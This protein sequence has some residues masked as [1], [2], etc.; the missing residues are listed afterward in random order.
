MAELF[1]WDKTIHP[2]MLRR[3]RVREN[4]TR[5]EVADQV[6]KTYQA[7]LN[8]EE[9]KHAPQQK[10]L[11]AIIDLFGEASFD[12]QADA[13]LPGDANA[14]GLWL[15]KRREEVPLT[16]HQFAETSGI[17]YQTIYN[18]ETGRTANPQQSTIARI[19][20][21]LGVP[22]PSDVGEDVREAA[23][24]G[25]EGIGGLTDFDPHDE[26]ELPRVPGIY[27]LYDISDRPIYIGQGVVIADRIK[28]RHNGHWDKFWYRAPI[29]DKGAFVRIED[30]TL[31]KQ[32]EAVMIKL[33]KSNAVINKQH[34]DR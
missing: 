25:V 12:P 34:V 18:I 17:S 26:E 2:E 1:K 22:L 4:M 9:G 30:E 14:L 21:A 15:L 10:Q 19:E 3:A 11:L 8:W 27:V 24:V 13:S 33:L 5:Q 31:R 29:V 6:D 23:E 28:D 16:R 32:I 7:V 20:R